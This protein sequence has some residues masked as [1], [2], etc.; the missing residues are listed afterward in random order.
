MRVLL[1]SHSAALYG[2]QRS[3]LDLA[4]GLKGEDVDA[5]AT[6]PEDGPLYAALSASGIPV[7]RLPC[8]NWV[9]SRGRYQWYRK[10]LMNMWQA[11]QAAV[12]A[13]EEGFDL[14][15]TNSSVIPIG[16]MIAKKVGL[17]HVWHVREG[18]PPKTDF[19]YWPFERVRQFVKKSTRYMVG[20]SD[21]TCEGMRAFC[22]EGTIRRIYNGPISMS[23]KSKP[24][25]SRPPIDGRGLRMLCVGR[26][27]PAK[28]HDVAAQA[29]ALLRGAQY[30]DTLTIAG[31]VPDSFRLELQ[32]I[33][34]IGL[35]FAGYVA[36]TC[37]LY[38]THDVLLMTSQK[39]AFG[40][41]TLEA[42]SRGC[43]VVGTKSGGT[44]EII[45]HEETGMLVEPG[46][47][48]QVADAVNRIR[49][50]ADLT[51]SIRIAARESAFAR[52]TRERYAHDVATLYREALQ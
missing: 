48:V 35:Q 45:Q 38:D 47:A 22:P 21:H 34:P 32:R 41:V 14:I 2:A 28:G 44:P 33:A 9:F 4:I 29:F 16:A 39:E 30:E 50:D 37:T 8:R 6:V 36:D 52:F 18:M 23:E 3:L 27:G 46:N 42:M 5:V 40:R 49:A 43:V 15:H 10:L 51:E 31:E 12:W 17:P 19:F 13:R 20:I 24:L 1:I 11:R 26:S 7:R 25:A